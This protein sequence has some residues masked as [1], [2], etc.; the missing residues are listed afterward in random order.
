MFSLKN[1]ITAD[2]EFKRW[3]EKEVLQDSPFFKNIPYR[4]NIKILTN[5]PR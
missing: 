5:G 2:V 4:P 1:E 3:F